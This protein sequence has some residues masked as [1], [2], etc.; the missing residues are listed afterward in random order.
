MCPQGMSLE[1]VEVVKQRKQWKD[2]VM[3]YSM[4]EK[5]RDLCTREA[6]ELGIGLAAAHD[7]L[8]RRDM[9]IAALIRARARWVS[10]ASL[11]KLTPF[12][13]FPPLPPSLPVHAQTQAHGTGRC[14]EIQRVDGA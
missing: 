3:L 1:E 7:G 11:T 9:A 13:L 10:K 4:M 5:K 12:T 14:G 6:T 8:G 2:D